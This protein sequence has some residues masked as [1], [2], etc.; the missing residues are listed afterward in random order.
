MQPSKSLADATSRWP[1]LAV[2]L[3]ARPLLSVAEL[4]KAVSAAYGLASGAARIEVLAWL[5]GA[6]YEVLSAS[7][8]SRLDG[9]QTGRGDP[10]QDEPSVG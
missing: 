10:R 8:Q 2:Q 6:S 7:Q 5:D 1:A 3:R 4:T 9:D